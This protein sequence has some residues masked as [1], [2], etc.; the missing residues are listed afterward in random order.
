[1][2]ALALLSILWLLAV[3]R[4]EVIEAA[5]AVGVDLDL[6]QIFQL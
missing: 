2:Q 3:V 4:E 1:M 5:A 6:E